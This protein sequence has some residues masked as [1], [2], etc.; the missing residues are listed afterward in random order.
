MR[1]LALWL[2]CATMLMLSP[3]PLWAQTPPAVERMRQEVMRDCRSAG[4]RPNLRPEF[5]S[6]AD[7]NGDGRPDYILDLSGLDCTGAES[8]FCGSAGCPVTIF[9][10][11][12]GGYAT[13]PMG[14]VQGWELDRSTNPPVLVLM[15]HGSACGRVGAEGCQQRLA[16]NGR[17]LAAVGRGGGRPPPQAAPQP[18]ASS[19]PGGWTLRLVAG[20][21]PVAVVPGPGVIANLALLCQEG[22][23]IAAITF[24]E[25]PRVTAAT[26]RF[27]DGRQRVD[28]FFSQMQGGGSAWYANLAGNSLPSLLLQREEALSLA[29]DTTVVGPLP[30]QGAGTAVRQA[31][32]PCLR[33]R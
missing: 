9:L 14:H 16:W 4:G 8:F 12:G 10:S 21:S 6:T 24:R 26:L 19:A 5:Q 28:V 23:A 17:E 20:R 13:K 25:P 3:A 29:I 11:T 2:L 31:L 30:R 7:L 27:S 33:I 18:G 15:L 22:R 1:A 32:A